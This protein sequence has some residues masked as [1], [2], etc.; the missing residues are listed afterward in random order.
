MEEGTVASGGRDDQIRRTARVLEVIQQIAVA[1]GRWS[2]RALAAHHE[3]SERMIQKDLELVRY[4]LGLKLV[5]DG[6]GYSFE[7]LPQLPTTAY[8]FGEAL[9]LLAAARAAQALPGVNSAE[10]AAAIARLESIFPDEWRPLLR[11]AT[12][13]LPRRAVKA[14]R[15]AMLTLLHRAL[16][17]RRQ[18]AVVYATASR[19]G[20]LSQRIF[21]PYH[22]MPYNRSWH[23]IAYDHQR[24][25]VLQFKV[26]RVQ[27]A[28]LLD[29]KYTI[30]ADFDLEAY[31]GDTWG[32]MRG[33]A[34]E[35]E[36][37]SLLFEAD[38]GRW[39][40]EEYWHKSQ[41]SETLPDGRV[42]LTLHVGITPEMVSW[43]LYYGDKV[44]VERP[45]WLR[46]EVC[47]AHQTAAL[48]CLGVS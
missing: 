46:Q 45:G 22:L 19:E 41:R 7:R 12:E 42:R 34:A 9:A 39:V 47:R 33:A 32:L 31:L 37:V 43:L 24:E 27:E 36:E 6:V 23:L 11:E 8:S 4:R 17:E 3:V 16:M 20:E 18:V 13:Q 2:R 28:E 38:A 21:E 26:D 15:Q 40:A 10:L 44:T 1:P 25:K 30:P 29:T 5:H 48:F 14:H 35:P